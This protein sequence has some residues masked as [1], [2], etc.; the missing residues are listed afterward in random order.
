MPTVVEKARIRCRYRDAEDRQCT[1]D[2]LENEEYRNF[3][4]PT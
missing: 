4:L 3:R 1:L 2:A